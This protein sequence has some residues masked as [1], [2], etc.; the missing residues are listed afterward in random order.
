MNQKVASSIPRQG[1][2]PGPCL[3]TCETQSIDVSL[4]YQ[5]FCP[6]LSLSLPLS[7]K[8]NKIL[9]KRKKERKKTPNH[10]S[11]KKVKFCFFS[12]VKVWVGSPDCPT[13]D[14]LFSSG[15]RSQQEATSWLKVSASTRAVL[16]SFQSAGRSR[17]SPSHQRYSK[18]SLN[19]VNR[20]YDFK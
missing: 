3:G 17:A 10:N 20:F 8:I 2:C 4:T 19:V 16:S 7:L 11:F 12:Q 9:K 14:S 6:S 13:R 5:C 1:M 18:S 15:C